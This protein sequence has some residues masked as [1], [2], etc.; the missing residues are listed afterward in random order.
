MFDSRVGSEVDKQGRVGNIFIFFK[1]LFEELGGFYINIYGSEDDGEVVFMVVVDVFGGIGMF[2]EIGLLIDLGGNLFLVI[3]NS[4]IMM[5]VIDLFYCGED[6]W[7][8]RWEFF[9]YE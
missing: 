4:L 7:Q 5:V 9:V 2:D 8:R 1:V 3:S 6:W